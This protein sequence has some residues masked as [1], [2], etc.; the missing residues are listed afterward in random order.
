M[1]ETL[2]PLAFTD[3]LVLTLASFL[4]A[5]FTAAFGVGGGAFL[6]AVMAGYL[7][8]MA[9]IPLH[10]LVQMGSNASRAIMTRQY[11]SCAVFGWFA[12]GAVIA[13]LFSVPLIGWF[14]MNFI[15]PLIAV[16]ILW[17]CWGTMPALGL[18]KNKMGLAAGGLVTTA[19]TMLVGA[20]GPLLAAW[21]GR[22]G[23]SRWQYTANFASCMTLQHFLKVLVF[24]AAG[25]SFWQWLPL[26]GLMLL[27]VFAGT[28]LGLL[29]LGKLPEKAFRTA[30]K[31]LLTLLSLHLLWASL[32]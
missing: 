25:F 14:D 2:F 26:V 4:G 20:T 30:F 24:V 19:A 12:L 32:S 16:F 29:C 8:A 11:F 9:L 22:E 5:V 28:R 13:A 18:G 21:L 31:W 10:G 1:L 3:V 6:L 27:G 15:K 23:V 7:P 17:L